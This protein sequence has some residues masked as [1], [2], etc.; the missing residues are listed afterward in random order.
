MTNAINTSGSPLMDLVIAHLEKDNH[1][2]FAAIKAA[3]EKKG[4]TLYPITYGRAKALLGLVPTAKR[5]EGKARLAKVA[6]EGAPKRGPGRPRKD[7]TMAAPAATAPRGPGRPRKQVSALDSLDALVASM[8]QTEA[9][10]DRLHTALQN[11]AELIAQ[12]LRG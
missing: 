6:A 2:P 9:S 5:G 10:R 7:A 11:A 8:R 12:A 4:L 3:A 1:A